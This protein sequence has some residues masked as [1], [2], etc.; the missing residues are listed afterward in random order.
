MTAP[1][2]DVV[3]LSKDSIWTHT[4]QSLTGQPW[5][6]NTSA[7]IQFRNTAGAL[8]ADIDAMDV[9]GQQ[10]RFLAQPE[11]VNDIPAGAKFAIFAEVDDGPLMVRH[12]TVIRV[13]PQFFDAPPS[14]VNQQRIFEDTFNRKVLGWKWET[15]T[16]GVRINQGPP[17]NLGPNIGLFKKRMAA[18][19]FYRQLAKDS[20]KLTVIARNGDNDDGNNGVVFC[21]DQEFRSGIEVQFD[22]VNDKV[23]I[24]RKTGLTSSSPLATTPGLV[25]IG[26]SDA[27]F[28]VLFNHLTNVV[29][30]FEGNSTTPLLEWFDD[31]QVIPHGNGY[32]HL[33]FVFRP[34]GNEITPQEGV[35]FTGWSARDEV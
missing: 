8:L 9:T 26:G 24:A 10:I 28:T 1:V 12:G 18:T 13:E 21:A 2:L 20:V 29:S 15:V 17:P 3:R 35:T 19:R 16:G 11:E 6:V 32:R 34:G 14:T 7:H 5:P 27:P 25:S 4:V 33:G 22:S 31:L 30:V 23:H